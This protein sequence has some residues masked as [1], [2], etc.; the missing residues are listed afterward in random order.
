M[1]EIAR[2]REHTLDKVRAAR[3]IRQPQRCSGSI[4][5]VPAGQAS[6]CHLQLWKFE[7][8]SFA[9][10]SS[11]LTGVHPHLT[12]PP[13]PC[14]PLPQGLVPLPQPESTRVEGFYTPDALRPFSPFGDFINPAPFSTDRT[15]YLMLHRVGQ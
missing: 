14:L 2:A 4:S 3:S 8:V 7:S 9:T 13:L 11:S 1:A 6:S 15:G 5:P 12:F 10:Q